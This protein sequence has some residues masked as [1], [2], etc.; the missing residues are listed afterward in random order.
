MRGNRHRESAPLHAHRERLGTRLI[1]VDAR[2]PALKAALQQAHE[3]G[4][5]IAADEKDKERRG[6]V[7]VVGEGVNNGPEEV[8]AEQQLDPWGELETRA[9]FG[10]MR[11]FA[12][13][14]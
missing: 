11:F 7:V 8:K 12:L 1:G 14:R 2:A 13:A 5:P 6:E 4:V 3:A 10:G 9:V